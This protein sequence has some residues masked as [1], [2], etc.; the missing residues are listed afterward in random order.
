MNAMTNPIWPQ[1][2]IIPD[3]EAKVREDGRVYL[4][5]SVD[6]PGKNGY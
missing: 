4:Y 1:E 2:C 6:I 5:G 3:V